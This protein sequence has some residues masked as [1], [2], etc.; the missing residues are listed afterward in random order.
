MGREQ[1]DISTKL[2]IILNGEVN[3]FR[4]SPNL[5]LYFQLVVGFWI[6]NIHDYN[7][8]KRVSEQ[9]GIL[10]IVFDRRNLTIS[11]V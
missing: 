6:K 9:T 11:S 10:L 4:V 1:N 3:K 5:F 8:I 2:P 7:G